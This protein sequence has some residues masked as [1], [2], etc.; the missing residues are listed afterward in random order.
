MKSAHETILYWSQKDEAFLAEV[1]E[2][3]GCVA[4][5]STRQDALASL[6]TVIAEWIET[7]EE[8]HNPGTPPQ[9]LTFAILGLI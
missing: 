1:P 7:V 3:P 9:P 5:S 8:S 2:L 6:E 4:D